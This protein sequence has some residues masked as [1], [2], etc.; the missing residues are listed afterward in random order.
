VEITGNKYT[1]NDWR[2]LLGT[3]KG[4]VVVAGVCAAIAAVI[5]IV[6]LNHYRESI[7]SSN[8][9]ETVLVSTG[10]IQKGTA[11]DA[12]ASEQRFQTQSVA[13]KQVSAG[14]IADTAQLHGRVAVTNI[15][16][17][18]Q[19]TAADFTASGGL[20]SQLSPS[21]RAVTISL[22]A[23]HGMLGQLQAGDH[24]DVYV[25]LGGSGAAVG[26][27]VVRLLM[28]NIT[29][30]KAG[31]APSS[32]LGGGNLQNQ[33]STV[34]LDVGDS[35]T[36][37]LVYAADAGK[38]WLVLRPANASTRPPANISAQTLLS[39][40]IPVFAGGEQ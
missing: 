6:A 19:L 13:A 10:E 32:G 36:G 5:L 40:S 30:L 14:A 21:Q 2:K 11:G 29:V 3:R 24:V 34:T 12:I 22:D 9:Q 26:G 20:A 17:G 18:Q 1:R 4:T 38:V 31:T 15:L 8:N 33:Q 28:G 37:A 35:Q 23:S 27:G 7:S 16:A 39:G 25:D